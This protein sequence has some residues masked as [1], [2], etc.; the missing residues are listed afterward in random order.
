[1]NCNFPPNCY[2]AQL[3]YFDFDVQHKTFL[4]LWCYVLPDHVKDTVKKVLACLTKTNLKNM[5]HVK[6]VVYVNCNFQNRINCAE[7][8]HRHLMDFDLFINFM[9]SNNYM[10]SFLEYSI[11][12]KYFIHFLIAYIILIMTNVVQ[13]VYRSAN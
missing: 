3:N 13:Y 1:M 6:I 12:C 4:M 5:L 7:V 11:M 10:F 9:P 2:W 8:C